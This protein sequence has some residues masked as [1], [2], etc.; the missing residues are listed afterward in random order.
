MR[1]LG[2]IDAGQRIK[3]QRHNGL[4]PLLHGLPGGAKLGRDAGALA[5]VPTPSGQEEACARGEEEKDL[6]HCLKSK[7]RPKRARLDG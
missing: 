5:Q 1:P 7:T 6:R 3:L 2:L 4:G